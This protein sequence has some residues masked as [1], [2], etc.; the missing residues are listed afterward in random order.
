MIPGESWIRWNLTVGA[1]I[2][3]AVLLWQCATG[4]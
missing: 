1:V 2:V 3:V 4:G